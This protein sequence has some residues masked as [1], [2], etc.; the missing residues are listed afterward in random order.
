MFRST[1]SFFRA[2]LVAEEMAALA[3]GHMEIAK[4]LKEFQ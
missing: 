2:V 1:S 3:S 4:L